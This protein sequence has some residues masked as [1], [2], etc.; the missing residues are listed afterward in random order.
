M[1]KSNNYNQL[2][3]KIQ[4]CGK[5]LLGQ[6]HVGVKLRTNSNPHSSNIVL[7]PFFTLSCAELH[8]TE[9]HALFDN[10]NIDYLDFKSFFKVRQKKV[11][12]GCCT[13]LKVKCKIR[14]FS[15]GFLL[16]GLIH[17]HTLVVKHATRGGRGRPPLLF[18]ENRKNCPDFVK[19]GTNCVHP[20]VFH[21]ECSFKSI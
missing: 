20:W 6:T 17:F 10:L 18:F 2:I 5:I 15:I 9:F 4:F 14:I 16:K 21:S 11:I 13:L 3:K 8:W 19:K 1:L 12:G 7:Q